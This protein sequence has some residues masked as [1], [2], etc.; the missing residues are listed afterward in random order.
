MTAKRW[1]KLSIFLAIVGISA[2]LIFHALYAVVN[3]SFATSATINWYGIE[4]ALTDE[5]TETLKEALSGV[6]KKEQP[7]KCGYDASFWI[8]FS[9][10]RKEVFCF[11]G[12]DDCGIVAMNSVTEGP[13]YGAG[14][15][16]RDY[17]RALIKKY[18]LREK[19]E[20]T[21]Q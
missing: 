8:R 19:W 3:L 17:I 13:F 18:E 15:E 7:S 20:E 5:E 4:E 10:G 1:I 2:L 9:N 14:N 12:T 6:W 21:R 11:P 16:T